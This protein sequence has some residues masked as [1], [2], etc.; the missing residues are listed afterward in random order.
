MKDVKKYSNG[1]KLSVILLVLLGLWIL[2]APLFAQRLIVEKHLD[3][4]DA[5]VVMSG[6]A[7]YQE[8]THKAAA[9][10]KQG[11]A[12]TILLTD[13]GMR[14]GWSQMEKRN[15]PYVELAKRELI[16]QG[17]PAENIEILPGEVTGTD[18]EA[19]ALT[20]KIKESKLD[21]V[22]IVTSAYHTR[23]ALW[24][25]REILSESGAQAEI[26]IAH[27]PTG[28]QTPPIFTWWLS[29]KGW[30]M[31]A[32]EYVKSAAYWLYY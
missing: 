19:K 10:Y 3:R 6:S 9:L 32:G 22:L 24:T 14:A 13:D 18:W 16:A 21:S 25:F 28:E 17:V 29:K 7:V 12:N 26:G 30:Q 20:R 27:A 11:I 4:A 15:V 2:L 1:F 5:I 31:V 23:R 8:R